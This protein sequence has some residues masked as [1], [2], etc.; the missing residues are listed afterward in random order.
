PPGQDDGV[1]R[2]LI[3][4]DIAFRVASHLL[5]QCY[6]GTENRETEKPARVAVGVVYQA[7]EMT[8]EVSER[9]SF[10]RRKNPC[11]VVD[12]PDIEILERAGHQEVGE[13]NSERQGRACDDF[14]R[15]PIT[16]ARQVTRRGKPGR[17]NE[18]QTRLPAQARKH[19][20]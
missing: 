11:G 1:A 12:V 7:V 3:E 5:P 8:K 15:P 18:Q 2:R 14:E 20:E 16:P 13:H 19:T 6:A 4:P 17:H 9:T 10:A